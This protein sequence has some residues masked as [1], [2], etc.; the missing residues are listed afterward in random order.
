MKLIKKRNPEK[1]AKTILAAAT[2]EFAKFG[3]SGARIDII[4]DRA[5]SNK[6]LIYHYFGSKE[7]LFLAVLEYAYSKIR[8]H[9]ANLNL[10]NLSP[11]DAMKKL[12]NFTFNYFLNNP[13]FIRLLNSEN[14]LNAKHLKQSNKILKMQL[15]LLSKLDAILIDGIKSGVFRH[16]VKAID[17]HITIAALGY[18]YLSNANTLEAVFKKNLKSKSSL[19]QRSQHIEDVILGYLRP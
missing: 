2:T 14:L 1:T 6:R 9:E 10:E 8:H 19:K 3:F 15:P 11:T 16:D 5:Q 7:D 12:V 18:F 13:D 4:A 17:L